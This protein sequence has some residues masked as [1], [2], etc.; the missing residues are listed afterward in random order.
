MKRLLLLALAASAFLAPP[1]S[2]NAG[3]TRAAAD[4]ARALKR[5]QY[6]LNATVPTD[7]DFSAHAGSEA[8]Y[9]GAVR[10]FID[11]PNFY[12]AVMRYHERVF[13]V[14]LP[15]EYLDEIQRTDIDGKELK[16]ARLRCSR[17]DGPRARFSCAWDGGD[18]G[19]NRT[20]QCPLS[21]E[22]PVTPFWKPE[23]VVWVCPSVAR[24]CGTNLS[25]CFVEYGN[26]NEAKNTELGT[27][28]AFDSRFTIVKSLSRQ[29]AG[30]ATAVVVDNWP[31]TKILEPGLTAVDGALAH[32]YGQTNHFDLKRLNVPADLMRQLEEVSLDDTRFNLV[33]TG[34]A[35]EHAGVLTTFGWLRRYEKNRTRANQLYER[36][37]C[38]KFTADLP[39]VFPQDPGNLRTRDGCKGC[40]ATLDPLADFYLSWGEGGDVYRGAGAAKKTTFAGKGGSSLAD[41]SRIIT[42]DEAF[43]TCAV[44]NAWEWMLGRKFYASEKALRDELTAY[45]VKTRY[46]F[47]E[48]V[49]ALATHPAFTSAARA[50]SVVTDPLDP[51]PLGKVPDATKKPCPPSVDFSVDIAPAAQSL[52]AACHDGS[53]GR[54][55][56]SDE[57]D[58]RRMG[59]T[60]VGMM[61]SGSMPP[62]Q[63]GPPSAGAVYELKEAARC[64]IEQE[65][66]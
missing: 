28:E 31:Y 64:W 3:E 40:H 2:P 33:Y 5:A 55:A 52:C 45:F 39:R 29:A 25:K 47:R 57:A 62:G 46:S 48:L 26:E 20:G 8:T 6:L 42:G 19:R 54:Q 38:R 59:K 43:A 15:G 63:S 12:D 18:T 58:W 44:Q 53:E 4:Y 41:L 7:A 51:P 16:I 35:Y 56:L 30:L 13:G 22:E 21:M 9:E 24:A 11:H 34:N 23:A 60:A 27:S 10:R 17:G 37:L 50:D 61:A 36:L 49:Y 65:G 32:L 14:G 66:L 1:L